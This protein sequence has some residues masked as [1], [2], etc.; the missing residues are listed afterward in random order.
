M[1]KAIEDITLTVLAVGFGSG[2]VAA[3][4]TFIAG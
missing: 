2:L 4:V 3:L 1:S